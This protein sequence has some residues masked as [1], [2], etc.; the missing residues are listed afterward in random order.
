[1]VLAGM[2]VR[3][4]R[5]FAL[6]LLWMFVTFLPQSLTSSGQLDPRYMI[7]SVSRYL[8]LP[9]VGASFLY[10]LVLER[11]KEMLSHRAVTGLVTAVLLVYG[12]IHT[13]AIWHR[14]ATWQ[15]HAGHMKSFV[16]TARQAVPVIPPRSHISVS[17]SPEGTAFTMSALRAIYR[18]PT[19]QWFGDPNV[20]QLPPGELGFV[21]V[22]DQA[23]QTTKGYRLQ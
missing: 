16:T 23:L 10:A 20:N 4:R 21:F 13:S 18:D 12:A 7:N 15:F 14:G 1:V 3:D 22:Y 17:G 5:M 6:A 2:L 19:F 9:V 8:Y 11:L